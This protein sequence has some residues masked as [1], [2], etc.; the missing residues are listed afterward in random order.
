ML[1]VDFKEFVLERI[2][3]RPPF[4]WVDRVVTI[5]ENQLVAEKTIPVDLDIFQGHYPDY[6]IMPGVILCEAV[7]QAGAILIAE[8]MRRQTASVETNAGEQSIPVLTR[9]LGAKFKREVKPGE[10]IQIKV[11]LK[12]QVGSA[13]FLS[14]KILVNDRTAV[15]VDFACALK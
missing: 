14:G 7:F 4:L 3:H 2:P 5:E 10:V 13:W 15:K 1:P 8:L 9:I 6:P 12:E 11:K